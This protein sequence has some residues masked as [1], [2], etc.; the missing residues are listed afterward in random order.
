M[1][2]EKNHD[3]LSKCDIMNH[4]R[5]QNCDIKIHDTPFKREMKNNPHHFN[6]YTIVPHIL[7]TKIAL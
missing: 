6:V 4:D 1:F 3:P 5:T 2:I 7:Y